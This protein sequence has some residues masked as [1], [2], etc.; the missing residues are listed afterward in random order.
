M[1]YDPNKPSLGMYIL[2]DEV[3]VLTEDTIEW[4]RWMETHNRVVAQAEVHNLFVSTVFLGLDHRM[5]R[6]GQDDGKAILF[7]T[8]VFLRTHREIYQDRYCS[9]EEA[10]E[11]HALAC[12]WCEPVTHSVYESELTWNAP[13][14]TGAEH[15]VFVIIHVRE[16]KYWSGRYG[17]NE[18]IRKAE[19]FTHAEVTERVD[20]HD[21]M[22][23]DGRW[24][25]I[26]KRIYLSD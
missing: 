11:G 19:T 1:V 7:E 24:Y 4:G 17:W 8:M 20:H 15:H 16:D 25:A 14:Y 26:G 5:A 23:D 13:F 9:I 3:P 2:K 12:Q 21:P 10:R 6:V 22:P 18:D